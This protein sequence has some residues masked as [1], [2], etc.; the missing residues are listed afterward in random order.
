MH[1]SLF[2]DR[3]RDLA[4]QLQ[5]DGTRYYTIKQENFRYITYHAVGRCARDIDSTTDFAY[6]NTTSILNGLRFSTL[7]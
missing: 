4:L 5:I 6:Y 7:S 1:S 3:L 2:S